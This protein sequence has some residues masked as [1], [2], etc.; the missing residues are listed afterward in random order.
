MNHPP[1]TH[2]RPSSSFSAFIVRAHY[3]SVVVIWNHGAGTGGDGGGG[4]TDAPIDWLIDWTFVLGQ[5]CTALHCCVMYMCKW[6]KKKKNNNKEK[7]AATLVF[8]IAVEIA[9]RT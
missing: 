8:I 2:G 6:P 1:P 4:G 5:Q 3:N 9:A 7:A